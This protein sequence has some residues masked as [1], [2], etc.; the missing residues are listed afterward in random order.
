MEGQQRTNNRRFDTRFYFSTMN[1][2]TVSL[3]QPYN[4]ARAQLIIFYVTFIQK[5]IVLSFMNLFFNSYLYIY[6]DAGMPRTAYWLLFILY[7]NTVIQYHIIIVSN[8]N[9]ICT[10]VCHYCSIW[11]IIILYIYIRIP[12]NTN[13]Y[14]KSNGYKK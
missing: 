9:R 6:I 13:A 12:T 3:Y 5:N 1:L 2:S 4:N 11:F 8:Q 10:R 7:N 14:Q